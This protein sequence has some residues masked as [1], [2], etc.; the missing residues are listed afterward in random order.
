MVFAP[1]DQCAGLSILRLSAGAAPT[2][3]GGSND[4]LLWVPEHVS[5]D[6]VRPGDVYGVAAARAHVAGREG[7]CGCSASGGV[8]DVHGSPGGRRPSAGEGNSKRGVGR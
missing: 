2:S 5:A 4:D 7:S 6:P 1:I 3:E 8:P